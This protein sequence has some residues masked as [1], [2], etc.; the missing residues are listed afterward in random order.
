M[1]N[2]AK[3]HTKFLICLFLIALASTS[4][5][6]EMTPLELKAMQTRKFSKSAA[7]VLEAI[8]V[9]GEDNDGS[10]QTEMSELL[11]RGI[12]KSVEVFCMYS[13]VPKPDP[14]A[15]LPIVGTIRALKELSAQESEIGMV[16]YQVSVSKNKET[17]VRMRIYGRDGQ[18]A[19]TAPEIYSQEFKRIADALFIQAIEINPALQE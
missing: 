12:Q 6:A 7:E 11:D 17:I 1:F 16:K 2:T 8:K 15:M 18:S 10:C 4:Q 13:K 3:Q 14:Y 9:S 19:I 5:A